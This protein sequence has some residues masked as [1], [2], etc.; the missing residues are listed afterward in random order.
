[1][2]RLAD[3]YKPP[4]GIETPAHLGGHFGHTHVDRGTLEWAVSKLKVR[5][6]VDV[7]CGPGGMV[8]AALELGIDAIG[9]D[10]DPAA[11]ALSGLPEDRF[12]LH[13][14]TAG[15]P[16]GLGT[17]DLAWSV[18]FLEHVEQRHEAAYFSVFQCA[19]LVCPSI[20]GY[21]VET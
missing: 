14:F 7:G 20:R 21:V 15:P 12:I 4:P 16:P 19:R 6:M 10:G 1:M 13:D 9:I 2:A 8:R 5:R 17:F 11:R 3:S 18:E